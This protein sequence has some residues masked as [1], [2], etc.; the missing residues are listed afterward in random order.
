MAYILSRMSAPCLFQLPAALFESERDLGEEQL[1]GKALLLGA[2]PISAMCRG[3]L[4]GAEASTQ[5]V[6]VPRLPGNGEAQGQGVV[7]RDLS[8]VNGT[9]ATSMRRV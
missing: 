8:V 6:R 1:R 7:L 9:T 2:V 3:R 4:Q 5:E